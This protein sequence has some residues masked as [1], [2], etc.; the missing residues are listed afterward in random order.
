MLVVVV[1]REGDGRGGSRLWMREIDQH[2]VVFWALMQKGKD[3]RWRIRI[4][5]QITERR[6]VFGT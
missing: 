3:S 6:E 2:L 1:G 4:D 5:I